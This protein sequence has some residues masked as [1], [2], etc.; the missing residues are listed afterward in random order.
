MKITILIDEKCPEG[1]DIAKRIREYD[2][3]QEAP[4]GFELDFMESFTKLLNDRI[5]VNWKQEGVCIEAK[6]QRKKRSKNVK[7]T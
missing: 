4:Y 1:K 5:G 6:I 7:R 2:S 3:K